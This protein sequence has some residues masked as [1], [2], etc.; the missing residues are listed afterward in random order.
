MK[1]MSLRLA[2]GVLLAITA[3]GPAHAGY[4]APSDPSPAQIYLV[5]ARNLAEAQQM[6]QEVLKHHPE[7]SVAHWVAAV[8]DVRAA[9]FLVA[10]QELA[11]AEQLAPGLPFVSP[12]VV[13]DLQRQ[14]EKTAGASAPDQAVIGG[15]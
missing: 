13:A 11:R 9:N 10:S 1:T 3:A 5:A 14:L 7:S 6:V 2:F 12:H 8:L 15:R 4:S